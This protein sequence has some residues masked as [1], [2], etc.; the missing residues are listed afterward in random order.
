MQTCTFYSFRCQM[1]FTRPS[2]CG[3]GRPLRK[4]MIPRNTACIIPS[5]CPGSRLSRGMRFAGLSPPRIVF[6]DKPRPLR[7]PPRGV[8]NLSRATLK[9]TDDRFENQA[10]PDVSASSRSRYDKSE[11]MARYL[12]TIYYYTKD[13][14]FFSWKCKLFDY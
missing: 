12:N 11:E 1:N 2:A 5:K 7:Q 10:F 6:L 4:F 8:A 3:A 13:F 14:S 9:M